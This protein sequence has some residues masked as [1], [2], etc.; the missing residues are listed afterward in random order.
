MKDPLLVRGRDNDC[1]VIRGA[2]LALIILI[3]SIRELEN[4]IMS[5]YRRVSEGLWLEIAKSKGE[6]TSLTEIFAA[7]SPHSKGGR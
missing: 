1:G 2:M 5:S 7:P 6:E 3:L 4:I